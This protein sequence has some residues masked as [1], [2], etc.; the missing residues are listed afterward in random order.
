MRDVAAH[1][2]HELQKLSKELEAKKNE[3]TESNKSNEKLSAQLTELES[4][5]NDLQEQ[6]RLTYPKTSL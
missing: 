3:L 4:T 2:K 5:I 6:V 1:E